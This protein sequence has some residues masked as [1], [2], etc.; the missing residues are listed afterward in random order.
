MEEL[1][2]ILEKEEYEFYGIRM[3]NAEYAVG[4]TCANSHQW[5]QDDPED[6]EMEYEPS[7]GCWDGGELDGTCAFEVS[8]SNL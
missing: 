2:K 4:D 1:K 7:M 6:D 3:D 8:A 5:W